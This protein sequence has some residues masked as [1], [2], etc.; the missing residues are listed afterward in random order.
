MTPRPTGGAGRPQP[1]PRR[2]APTRTP[3][4]GQQ[5][6]PKPAP[7]RG[8]GA[9]QQ[10]LQAAER[11]RRLQAEQQR[12]SAQQHRLREQQYLREAHGARREAE[13]ERRT[14]ELRQRVSRLESILSTGLARSA[15]IDLDALPRDPE[16][17]PFDPGPLGTPAPE[18]VRA[19]FAPRPFAGWWGGRERRERRAAAAQEAYERARAEWE[20]A[21]QERKRRLADAERAHADRVAAERAETE[22]YNARI[23]RV[24]AGLRERDPRVVESFLR[25]VLRRVPLPADFP[26]RF[27]VHHRP[28]DERVL[29][30]LVLPGR[31][32]VPTASGF[33][34]VASADEIRPVPRPDEEVNERYRDVVAQVTLLVV[35][36]VF[37]AEPGLAGVTVEG[38]VDTVDP[39]DHRPVLARLV[40]LGVDRAAFAALDLDQLPPEECLRRLGARLSPDPY[41]YEPVAGSRS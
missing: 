23:A 31:E 34:F 38:L 7:A 6:T 12:R 26:R 10:R 39:G 28:H 33:E 41:A 21:E 15:R 29:V 36:D 14:E 20:R 3:G 32:V 35:R 18:P 11:Q 17:A 5:R 25:T 9:E 16:P 27:E 24:A 30:R 22:R 1:A 19:D 37:E 8:S 2:A 4:A 40:R 13:A